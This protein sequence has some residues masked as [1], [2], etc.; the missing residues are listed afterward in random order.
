LGVCNPGVC[1]PERDETDRSRERRA[2]AVD[3]VR[4]TWRLVQHETERADE[5]KRHHDELAKFTGIP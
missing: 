3:H 2:A 4:P 1:A 5:K